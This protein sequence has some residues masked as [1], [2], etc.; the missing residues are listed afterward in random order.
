MTWV[1]LNI[2]FFTPFRDNAFLVTSKKSWS[3]WARIR[4]ATSTSSRKG[5]PAPKKNSRDDTCVVCEEQRQLRRAEKSRQR[6][7][8][9]SLST[10]MEMDGTVMCPNRIFNRKWD[11]LV[12]WY[13]STDSEFVRVGH[14]SKSIQ[15]NSVTGLESTWPT[16]HL[17]SHCVLPLQWP[18]MPP[19]LM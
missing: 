3:I 2:H 1:S 18:N 6:S 4:Y 16:L 9:F 12:R 15:N 17:N 11:C 5:K 7:R 10:A 8:Q 13:F 14:L 19:V